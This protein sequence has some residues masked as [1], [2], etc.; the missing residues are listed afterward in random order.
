MPCLVFPEHTRSSASPKGHP[1]L[2]CSTV[3]SQWQ[4]RPVDP[5]PHTVPLFQTGSSNLTLGPLLRIQWLPPYQNTT[6]NPCLDGRLLSTH[7]SQLPPHPHLL[8]CVQTHIP[9]PAITGSFLLLQTANT[10]PSLL[11]T[12]PTRA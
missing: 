3:V 12:L 2:T 9:F 7:G 11:T 1:E 5:I 10:L 8:L 4:Q 6:Q